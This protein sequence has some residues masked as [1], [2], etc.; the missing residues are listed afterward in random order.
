MPKF[1]FYLFISLFISL[2]VVAWALADPVLAAK[3][4]L[5][6][7]QP[8]TKTKT[9]ISTGYSSVRLSRPSNS[10]IATFTNLAAVKKV[11]YV[12]SYKAQGLD[13]G[14]MGSVSPAG[15]ASDKRDLY[16]GTCSHGVCTP[17]RNIT[18]SVLTVTT[19]LKNGKTSIKRYRIKV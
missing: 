17:H 11:D 10:I 15:T 1:I 18:N 13:Q 14:A 3:P 12:L 9:S 7:R 16:F 4:R 19:S 6:P 8:I 5:S 2:P